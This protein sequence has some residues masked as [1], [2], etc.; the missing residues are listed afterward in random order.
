[1]KTKGRRREEE[2]RKEET[3]GN[4]E[5]GVEL[6][7][8]PLEP[9]KGLNLHPAYCNRWREGGGVEEGW[10]RGGG[11]VEEGWKVNKNQLFISRCTGGESLRY[12]LLLH[13]YV[14]MYVCM[15]V[16]TRMY[17]CTCVYD[18]RGQKMGA[19]IAYFV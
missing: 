1:M 4:K 17:V 5:G 10:W 11:G 13:L 16:C 7:S 9:L 8:R 15:C 18:G 6:F 14:C 19:V 12:A 3:G 2:G